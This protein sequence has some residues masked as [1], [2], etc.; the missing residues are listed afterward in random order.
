MRAAP[1][2]AD[3]LS[4]LLV[5]LHGEPLRVSSILIT[6]FGDAIRPR[7]GAVGAAT[8]TRIAGAMGIEAGAVRTALSRLAAEGWLA[9]E[10]VGRAAFYRLAPEGAHA[11]D[12]ATR[13]IYAAGPPAWDGRWT[14]VALPPGAGEAR[15]TLIERG[16]GT[17]A[18]ALLV[19]PGAAAVD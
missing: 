4:G 5:Q 19:H 2:S 7:G 6:V 17:L 9:R 11:F 15:K 3:P 12:A 1:A 18:P 13:R 14:V 16:F 8:L 10:R